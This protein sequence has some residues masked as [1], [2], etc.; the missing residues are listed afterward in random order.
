MVVLSDAPLTAD[1]LIAAVSGPHHGA[2]VVFLGIVRRDPTAAG[3][4]E[5]LHYEVH[6]SMTRIALQA[7]VRIAEAELGARVALAHRSGECAVGEIATIVA[8]GAGHRDAAF[9]AARLAIEEIKR[10]VPVWK[11]EVTA[12]GSGSWVEGVAL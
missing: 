2:I 4:V 6:P 12:A 8:A 11:R 3:E 5:S 7:V 1:P 10:T 9:A